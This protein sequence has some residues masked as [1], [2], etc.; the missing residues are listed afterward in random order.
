MEVGSFSFNMEDGQKEG[1]IAVYFSS[2]MGRDN[3]EGELLLPVFMKD[4]VPFVDLKEPW[5]PFKGRLGQAHRFGI[6]VMIRGKVYTTV[7]VSGLPPD[8]SWMRY[9]RDYCVPDGNIVCK[10][11]VGEVDAD[12]VIAA[13]TKHEEEVSASERL[14][15]LER[16][17]ARTRQQ[18]EEVSKDRRRLSDRYT[19]V[20][21]E[22][23][24]AAIWK[25]LALQL[26][27]AFAHLFFVRWFARRPL[28]RIK[29]LREVSCDI[30]GS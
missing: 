24:R 10:Y 5:V 18:L 26:D 27:G 23:D 13:A 29:D 8:H 21:G 7:D 22:R 11:L 19:E 2:G 12:A 6:E 28:A 20:L 14:P 25:E 17:L 4:G 3:F 30:T 9:K 1:M 16:E 15:E